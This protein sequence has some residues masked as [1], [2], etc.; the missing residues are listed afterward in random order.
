MRYTRRTHLLLTTG[1][2]KESA[3]NRNSWFEACGPHGGS[4]LYASE[5]HLSGLD[6][7]ATDY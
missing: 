2:S 1:D 7:L 3:V 6:I 4:D 5:R